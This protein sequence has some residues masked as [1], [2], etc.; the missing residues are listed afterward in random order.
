MADLIDPL[1]HLGPACSLDE[2]CCGL[3]N[4][5]RYVEEHA[6]EENIVVSRSAERRGRLGR[7]S[8]VVTWVPY[9]VSTRRLIKV[10]HRADGSLD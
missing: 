9:N 6:V 4:F 5:G 10:P 2:T 1:R 8:D 7:N 3:M